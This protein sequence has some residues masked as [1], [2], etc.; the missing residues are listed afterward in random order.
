M[1][2]ENLKLLIVD[3]SVT[4]GIRLRTLLSPSKNVSIIGH[5]ENYKEA[6]IIID[7]MKPDVILL[8]I[9]MP[10]KNGI[11]LLTELKLKQTNAKIIMCTNDDD[12]FSKNLCNQLGADFFLDKS[13]EFQ[14]IPMI[15]EYLYNKKFHA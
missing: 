9:Q 5:A 6:S 15:L 1:K 2:P 13:T 14:E 8:D 11:D 12:P 3:D 10:G 4:V 7:T